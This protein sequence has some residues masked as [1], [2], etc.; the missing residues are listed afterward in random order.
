VTE[1]AL[2]LDALLADPSK[3]SLVG[4]DQAIELLVELAR[5]ER[6]LELRALAPP[7]SPRATPAETSPG[8]DRLLDVHEAAR[9]LGL[10]DRQLY[11]RAKRFPFTVKLG[12]GTLRFSEQGIARHLEDRLTR[13]GG[14]K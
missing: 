13:S 9:R 3:A 14:G 1:R 6:A 5:V 7:P 8:E 4:R 2:L 10:S 11:R 12:P